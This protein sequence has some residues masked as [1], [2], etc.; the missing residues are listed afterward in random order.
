MLQTTN[1][2][3]EEFWKIIDHI[4]GHRDIIYL[5]L[6][7]ICL[8][9]GGLVQKR[10]QSVELK[11]W[12][13]TCMGLFL[14]F[15]IMGG[16]ACHL[17][18]AMIFG[19]F[20]TLYT[21]KR[22]CHIVVF[23]FMMIYLTLFRLWI[24]YEDRNFYVHIN[25]MMMLVTC[26]LAGVAFEISNYQKRN[27][28]NYR[29]PYPDE[30]VD[31][32]SPTFSDI[33]HYTF[34]YIGM[35]VGPY[36]RYRTFDD[37]IK[38]PFARCSNS[39]DFIKKR[40]PHVLIHFMLY[41]VF[42]MTWPRM[43]IFTEEFSQRSFFYK[44][45]YS[46]IQFNRFKL[47]I[48]FGLTMSECI[49]AAAGFG[50]YPVTAKCVS[51]HGPTE[52]YKD[53]KKISYEEALDLE[54]DFKAISCIDIYAIQTTPWYTKFIRVWNKSIQYFMAM[55]IYRSLPRTSH[56]KLFWPIIT[57]AVC[58]HWH[59]IELGY[60][61]GLIFIVIHSLAE[62]RFMLV[63]DN[64]SPRNSKIFTIIMYIVNTY[65]VGFFFMSILLLDPSK[66]Y[67]YYSSV[68]FLPFAFFAFFH[69]VGFILVSNLKSKKHLK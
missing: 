57:I 64:L 55:Y 46:V 35:I 69:I 45:T 48:V 59:G 14:I 10:I 20:L 12:T 67:V 36:I 2:Y 13:G 27:D 47:W 68:Q 33:L 65:F 38:L 23:G 9:F 51:T 6:I 49:C 61:I 1:M 41:C 50:A 3:S 66:I 7:I 60:Q 18:L 42:N 40:L 19:A 32:I 44:F 8:V 25:F 63:N 62:R 24:M 30:D 5:G 16:H 21:D 28:I 15:F 37:F 53:L 31:E 11:K 58:A 52:N 26:K 29:K 54:Y 17:I 39:W 4:F 22:R 43:Y 56:F 34:S